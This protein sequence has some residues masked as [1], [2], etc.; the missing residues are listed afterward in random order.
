M[1]C[2]TCPYRNAGFSFKVE[3]I[4]GGKSVDGS[5]PLLIVDG[6]L[7]SKED[8]EGSV[9]IGKFLELV[10]SGLEVPWVYTRAVRCCSYEQ[11]SGTS[12]VTPTLEVIR[13][14]RENVVDLIKKVEPGAIIYLGRVAM[15]SVLGKEAPKSLKDAM[16]L[17][18]VNYKGIPVYGEVSP[19]THGDLDL[20]ERYFQLFSRAEKVCNN[21]LFESEFEYEVWDKGIKHIKGDPLIFI[22]VESH[23]T[24]QLDDAMTL[25]HKDSH[26]LCIGFG[27]LEDGKYRNIV[28]PRHMCTKENLTT[29]FKGRRLYAHNTQYDWLAIRNLCGVDLFEIGRSWGDTMHDFYSLDIGRR[30]NGLKALAAKHL[31]APP[32][33]IAKGYREQAELIR[34]E[35]RK[36]EKKLKLP[37]TEIYSSYKDIP[38]KALYK[39]NALDVYWTARLYHEY[40]EESPRFQQH[41][42]S[43]TYALLNSATEFL[44]NIQQ[45]GM[46]FSQ[47]LCSK[48]SEELQEKVKNY[49]EWMEEQ[50]EIQAIARGVVIHKDQTSLRINVK[51]WDKATQCYRFPPKSFNS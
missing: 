19:K 5:K 34:R 47:E 48:L 3:P 14:C 18:D 16:G 49:K 23:H 26:I 4:Y 7:S 39:Y 40:L 31:H 13:E 36:Q 42:N 20:T 24:E 6:Y 9:R 45:I 50:P 37:L 30:G 11:S 46:P 51:F 10:L 22:D 41:K 25:F 43:P 15:Q 12:Q 33:D 28:L 17:V 8:G 27:Y 21:T 35:R 29:L 1:G 44:S 2:N 32:W 38:E